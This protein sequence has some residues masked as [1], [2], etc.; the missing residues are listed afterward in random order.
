MA[1]HPADLDHGHAGAVG[2]HDGHLQDGLELGPDVLRGGAVEGLGAVAALED[3]GLAPGHGGQPVAQL[4][5]LAG[6]DER[7][8]GG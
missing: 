7:G 2:E 1:G 8:Q 4:V 3:E 5:A 6:E